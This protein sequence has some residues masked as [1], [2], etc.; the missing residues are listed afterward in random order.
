MM[1]CFI[2]FQKI[3]CCLMCKR[4]KKYQHN[5]HVSGQFQSTQCI[6][7]LPKQAHFYSQSLMQLIMES[8]LR[9]FSMGFL[10]FPFSFFFQLFLRHTKIL[11]LRLDA[12]KIRNEYSSENSCV[13][14]TYACILL[15]YLHTANAEALF[16]FKS[17]SQTRWVIVSSLVEKLNK[18]WAE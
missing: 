2:L 1:N 6:L 13:P 15:F 17:F 8:I 16:R 9:Q 14:I 4:C 7:L 12:H 18:T 5:I 3:Q 11:K 10:F